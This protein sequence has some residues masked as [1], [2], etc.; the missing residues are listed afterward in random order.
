MAR[1]V[2]LILV[3]L[4]CDGKINGLFYIFKIWLSLVIVV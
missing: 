2:A 1:A 3:Q 4:A